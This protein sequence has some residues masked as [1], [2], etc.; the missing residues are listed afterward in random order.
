MT[1]LT[2]SC[3]IVVPAGRTSLYTSIKGICLPLVIFAITPIW[4]NREILRDAIIITHSHASKVAFIVTRTADIHSVKINI[5]CYVTDAGRDRV[6]HDLIS[7]WA[8]FDENCRNTVIT[9]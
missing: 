5:S 1:G 3:S 9:S 4:V 8:S 2:V 7:D 6:V